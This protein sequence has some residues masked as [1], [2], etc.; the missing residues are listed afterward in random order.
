[1][2]DLGA[3]GVQGLVELFTGLP[4]LR[5]TEGRMQT[6]RKAASIRMLGGSGEE[7]ARKICMSDVMSQNETFG[8]R[9][10]NVPIQHSEVME[11]A[12][13]KHKKRVEKSRDRP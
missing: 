6:H 13:H 12:L 1:M 7:D 11:T 4:Y 8:D 2:V 10:L 9:D 3:G 5:N